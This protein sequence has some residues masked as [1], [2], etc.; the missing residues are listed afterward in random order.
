MAG[1]DKCEAV[2][3]NAQELKRLMRLDWAGVSAQQVQ[4]ALTVVHADIG[5]LEQLELQSRPLCKSTRTEA[6]KAACK[7]RSMKIEEDAGRL[8]RNSRAKQKARQMRDGGAGKSSSSQD[9][10]ASDR[11]AGGDTAPDAGPAHGAS[12]AAAFPARMLRSSM[13]SAFK[14]E[15]Q[16]RACAF[17]GR[18]H[19]S[20]THEADHVD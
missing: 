15:K 12:A 13:A 11:F 14:Q 18:A 19:P 10:M 3:A 7:S 1:L 8:R 4:D 16:G 17:E 6:P 2:A 9:A 20:L 5:A